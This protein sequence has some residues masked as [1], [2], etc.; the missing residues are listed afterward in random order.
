MKEQFQCPQCGVK[1]SADSSYAGRKARCPKCQALIVLTS[2]KSEEIGF[3]EDSPASAP[4]TASPNP[5]PKSSSVP[6][7]KSS[8]NS[9]T[10]PVSSHSSSLSSGQASSGKSVSPFDQAPV[11][12]KPL[13]NSH[14][15]I[16]VS[17]TNSNSI[18]NSSS[19]TESG[20]D[21]S[22]YG[23]ASDNGFGNLDDLVKM[24]SQAAAKSDVS[25]PRQIVS[26]SFSENDSANDSS[27]ESS[28]RPYRS[29]SSSSSG[30]SGKMA[31]LESCRDAFIKNFLFFI[32]LCFF[33]F[34]SLQFTPRSWGYAIVAAPGFTFVIG[35]ITLVRYFKMCSLIWGPVG[36][37]GALIAGFIPLVNMIVFI[38]ALATAYGGGGKASNKVKPRR[39][40]YKSPILWIFAGVLIM[41]VVI[42]PAIL[43][44]LSMARKAGEEVRSRQQATGRTLSQ[45]QRADQMQKSMENAPAIESPQSSFP[46]SKTPFKDPPSTKSGQNVDDFPSL[47][48]AVSGKSL[49][50]DKIL[51]PL[52]GVVRFYDA[53]K[54]GRLD[55]NEFRHFYLSRVNSNLGFFF[56]EDHQ[57]WIDK[58]RDPSGNLPDF[59]TPDNGS[60]MNGQNSGQNP[61]APSGFMKVAKKRVTD[62]PCL[63]YAVTDNKLDINKILP[64]LKNIPKKCDMNSDNMLDENEFSAFRNQS[65]NGLSKMFLE[66]DHHELAQE[67]KER[68]DSPQKNSAGT[69]AL[70][71]APN[72]TAPNA[73]QNGSVR[74]NG[75][76]NNKRGNS[77]FP[78][79]V[80]FIIDGKGKMIKTEGPM[81]ISKMKGLGVP[82][83]AIELAQQ[84]DNTGNKDGFIDFNESFDWTRQIRKA[85]RN[86]KK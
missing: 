50:I 14:G 81:Q 11:V 65:H 49:I 79:N 54:N 84:I 29:S 19:Q 36:A 1:F 46:M 39:P 23:L 80:M 67:L 9:P 69:T 22:P 59:I 72:V 17:N 8:S 53:D 70:N 63:A 62:F 21:S 37:V 32:G 71:T 28:Y 77:D 38:M 82:D 41:I 6:V 5:V 27:L 10:S 7:P 61:Q 13:S 55:P 44:A 42:I 12:N 48:Y 56:K 74:N 47:S 26:S 18:L 3:L 78:V 25:K 4:K 57:Q 76:S 66:K 73:S 34:L 24:E 20:E 51:L 60:G 33:S 52:R 75:R 86:A 31:Q 30:D 85:E 68:K 64:E 58:N 45:K 43:V 35:I 2:C 40:F 83:F 15:K 16:P